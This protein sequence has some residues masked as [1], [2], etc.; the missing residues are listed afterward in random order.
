MIQW[1]IRR[2]RPR[3]AGGT[4]QQKETDTVKTTFI[5]PAGDTLDPRPVWE[6]VSEVSRNLDNAFA[7]WTANAFNPQNGEPATAEAISRVARLT[8]VDIKPLRDCPGFI[9]TWRIVQT[10]CESAQGNPSK[11]KSVLHRR[12]QYLIDAKA[13]LDAYRLA[14]VAGQ[15]NPNA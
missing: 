9:P 8:I 14:F 6:R 2:Y 10:L 15:D 11:T 1:C 7:D 5:I 13:A 4:D 3:F 12:A